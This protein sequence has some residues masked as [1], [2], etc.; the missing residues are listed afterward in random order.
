[1]LS[2][3]HISQWEGEM[4]SI[5]LLKQKGYDEYTESNPFNCLILSSNIHVPPCG[6]GNVHPPCGGSS[7]KPVTSSKKQRIE[8]RRSLQRR[9]KE[10]GNWALMTKDPLHSVLWSCPCS[11]N[12]WGPDCSGLGARREV[13]PYLAP[14]DRGWQ[15]IIL[16]FSQESVS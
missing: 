10:E 8:Q 11:Q 1:M 14:V 5:F 3:Q 4:T 12:G 6:Q 2:G 13:C 16:I 7:G 15:V 9:S